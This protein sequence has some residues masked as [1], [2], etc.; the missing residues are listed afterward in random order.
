ML[1]QVEIDPVGREGGAQR[2]AQRLRF[3]REHWSMPSTRAAE[4]PSAPPPAPSRP[5]PDRRPARAVAA[6]P[7]SAPLPLGSS[8]RPRAHP[9]RNGG[10][11]GPTRTRSRH[12]MSGTP[13]RPPRPCPGPPDAPSREP[14]RFPFPRGGGLPPVLVLGHHEV[15]PLE[16][17]LRANASAHGLAGARCLSRCLERLAGPQQRLRRDAGPVVALAPTSSRSTIATR[18]PASARRPAQCSPA[19]PAPTTMTSNS[20]LLSIA[21]SSPGLLRAKVYRNQPNSNLREDS[22]LI[23]RHTRATRWV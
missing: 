18:R 7:P 19:G 9:G 14:P 13:H 22:V 16:G 20:R 10:K 21:T 5:P 3:A 23:I 2:V 11:P 1:S 17:T 15:A 12:G 4:A 8:R 6:A